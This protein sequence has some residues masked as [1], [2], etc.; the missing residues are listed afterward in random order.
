MKKLS[1]IMLTM[2]LFSAPAFSKDKEINIKFSL[3]PISSLS[4]KSKTGQ[5]DKNVDFG[6][7][8]AAEYLMKVYYNFLRAG[9]GVEFV[10][11]RVVKYSGE[12]LRF[13]YLPLY[14]TVKTNPIPMNEELFFKG[15]IGMNVYSDAN[16][17]AMRD[18]KGNLYWALSLGYEY[19]SGFIVDISYSSYSS[20]S[21]TVDLTY[22][23]LGV[24]IGYKFNI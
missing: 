2:L 15:N 7:T 14:F 8:V 21:S 24:D 9:A 16:E 12:D 5:Q 18:K 20:L 4:L 1:V 17:D 13:C 3:D 6:I 11:P 22:N 23:K 19:R 10:T